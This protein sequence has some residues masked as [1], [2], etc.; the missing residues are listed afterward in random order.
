M[1]GGGGHRNAAPPLCGTWPV[2]LAPTAAT[3]ATATAGR[4][5]VLD[6]LARGR[7]DVPLATVQRRVPAFGLACGRVAG[8]RVE[9]PVVVRHDPAARRVLVR[10]EQRALRSP[11]GLRLPRALPLEWGPEA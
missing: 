7:D 9:R 3:A 10:G 1:L 2:G 5:L 11:A 4:G 6:D 8:E